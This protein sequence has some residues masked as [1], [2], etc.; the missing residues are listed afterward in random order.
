LPLITCACIVRLIPPAEARVETAESTYGSD[1][2]GLVWGYQFAPGTAPVAI[3][4]EELVPW[5]E[6]ASQAT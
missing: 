3:A 1:K 2:H 4:S 6:A 5:T